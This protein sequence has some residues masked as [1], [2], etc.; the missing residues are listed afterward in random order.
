MPRGVTAK[1][2]AKAAVKARAQKRGFAA[3]TAAAAKGRGSGRGAITRRPAA[4]TSSSSS[5]SNSDDTSRS[6]SSPGK[7]KITVRPY[8]G[9]DISDPQKFKNW[10]PTPFKLKKQGFSKQLRDKGMTP[11]DIKDKFKDFFT[12]GELTQLMVETAREAKKDPKTNDVVKKMK[13]EQGRNVAAREV[14]AIAL[15]DPSAWKQNLVTTYQE[16]KV[17]LEKQ[18]VEEKLS[19]GELEQRCGPAEAADRIRRGKW[20]RESDSD[21]DSVFVKRSKKR[22]LTQGREFR[23]GVQRSKFTDNELRKT[24]HSK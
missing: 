23:A 7:G 15:C 22:T 5:D 14:A 6:S 16:A 11:K 20:V 12:D 10:H 1:A 24:Q 21:G 2:K 13:T 4:A 17:G 3:R 18:E 19:R 8:H 9:P